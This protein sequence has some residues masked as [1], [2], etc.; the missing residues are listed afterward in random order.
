VRNSSKFIPLGSIDTA[1]LGGAA[2]TAPSLRAE[3]GVS[4][5]SVCWILWQTAPVTG[6]Q[7]NTVWQELVIET[8]P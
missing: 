7:K 3:I 1:S 4:L 8:A 5:G 6:I 2:F